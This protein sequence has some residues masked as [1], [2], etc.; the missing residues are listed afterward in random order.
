MAVSVKQRV[1]QAFEQGKR[2]SDLKVRGIKQQTLYRYYQ[3]WKRGKGLTQSLAQQLEQETELP[4][5]T[6][7]EPVETMPPLPGIPF[8]SKLDALVAGLDQKERL[9]KVEA[10][11]AFLSQKV[12][13]VE[14]A[15]VV[16][17]IRADQVKFLSDQIEA[18]GR[19]IDNLT[20]RLRV[21]EVG[22]YWHFCWHVGEERGRQWW[23]SCIDAVTKRQEQQA[24]N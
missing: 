8:D 16:E 15:K 18:L 6:E 22:L 24:A 21:L 20:T 7:K 13:N 14:G 1:F 3:E 23:Q 9:E 19:K 4:T 17:G 12:E 5:E 11:L 10:T 2:P